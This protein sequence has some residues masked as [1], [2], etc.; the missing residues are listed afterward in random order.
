MAL[1]TTMITTAVSNQNVTHREGARRNI[2]VD[3]AGADLM[4]R[5][6][7]SDW[8]SGL[9]LGP[10]L[11][12]VGVRVAVDATSARQGGDTARLF[13]FRSRR[14][15]ATDPGSYRAH[16]TF[17]GPGGSKPLEVVVET[18]PGHTPLFLLSFAAERS[19]FG[20]GWH[21]LI[22]NAVPFAGVADG[23]PARPAFGW[24]TPPVLAAA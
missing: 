20:E 12:R 14:V 13:S 8:E 15:E 10:D 7:F 17:T 5:G 23:E 18:P 2:E 21:D 9:A 16:G 22:Q 6:R 24:L 4:L 1:E 3:I 19:D 11:D